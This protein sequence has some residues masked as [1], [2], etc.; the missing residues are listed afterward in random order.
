M[1]VLL[2]TLDTTRV[3]Y[4]SCYGASGK[5]RTEHF[6][7][8]AREGCRFDFAISAS[9]AT[10]MSHASILTGLNPYQ[11]GLRVMAAA[12]G[13]RLPQKTPT[14]ATILRARGY[15][16]AAF[17]SSFTVS[18]YF[19]FD[20]G[21]DHFDNGL[22]GHDVQRVFTTEP[23]G[24]RHWA[25]SKNQRRSD[26]TTDAAI[27][28]LRTLDAKS[29]A[30]MWVHYWDPHDP[31]VLPP[32]KLF[33]K[34]VSLSLRG[35]DA[36]RAAYAAEIRYVDMQ[37]GRLIEALRQTGRYDRTVIVVVADHGEGLG[38]H[39]WW[40]HRL[41]Y[42]EQLHVPLIVRVP[43]WPRGQVVGDLVRTID[44]L[45]TVLD[46]LQVRVPRG[47]AGRSLAAL[48]HGEA[49]PPRVAYAEMLNR[50]DLNSTVLETRPQD[51][52]LFA[53]IG[54]R[55]KL[56]LRYDHPEKSELYDLQ[57]DPQE[58]RNLYGERA[59]EVSRLRRWLDRRQAYSTGALGEGRV[60]PD[61]LRQ[62]KALGYVGDDDAGAE[63]A[64][65]QPVPPP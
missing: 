45:P 1:S 57:S 5:Q 41:L 54:R 28:W 23:D 51:G 62:L 61:A 16:T 13:Y 21:F 34:M 20:T 11:H 46:A 58:L 39:D 53:A 18:E 33:A 9:P 40:H 19:G 2:V 49:E 17:L 42:Q 26:A 44:I 4:L 38:Q 36:R 6:D 59:G 64:A 52:L 10:P 27:A 25:V 31:Y 48:A 60:S 3:D 24:R 32:R 63:P 7:A 56:I 14:L 8:L 50:Y 29:P 12:T 43:G 55:W 65:S 15:R 30:L 37:F 47:V 22:A 35:D